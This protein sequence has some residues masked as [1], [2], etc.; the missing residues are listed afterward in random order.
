MSPKC[1]NCGV[2][3]SED[4]RECP[5]CG[6]QFAEHQSALGSIPASLLGIGCGV[7]AVAVLSIIGLSITLLLGVGA[8]VAI[9]VWIL[10]ELI[11]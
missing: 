4:A 6:A 7:L 11:L 9:L 2:E 10:A 5:A 1:S 3:I 8:S